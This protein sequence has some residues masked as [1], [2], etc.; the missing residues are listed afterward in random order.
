[1]SHTFSVV[2]VHGVVDKRTHL[3]PVP[4]IA[5]AIRL[6]ETADSS[7]FKEAFMS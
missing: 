6:T 7:W 5:Q 3:R 1:M 4:F 2:C